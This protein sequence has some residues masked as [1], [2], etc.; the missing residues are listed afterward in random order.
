MALTPRERLARL[1]GADAPAGSFSAQTTESPAGLAPEVAGVGPVALPIRAAQAK[2]LIA[3]ARPASFGRGTKTLVDPGV[4]DTWELTPNQFTLDGRWQQ[5]LDGALD[6]LRDRLGLSPTARLWLE[7]HAM[8]VYG[9]G[10]FFL[11]H[12]DSEKHDAMVGSV[13]LWLPSV[14][15]GGEL[16]VEHAGTR[17]TYRGSRESLSFVAF[18][19]D[20][21]HEVRPVR[22]GHRVSIT[23]NLLAEEV[24]PATQPEPAA[25]VAQCLTEHFAQRA[26]SPY[27][28]RDLGLP[29]RLVFLLDHEYTE[30]G[31]AAN[32]L[33]GADTKRTALLRAAATQAGCEAVLALAEIKETWDAWPAEDNDYCHVHYDEDDEDDPGSATDE[34]YQLNDLIEAEIVLGWWIRPD[35]T[36]GEPISL[37][38]PEHEVCTATPTATLT[39]YESAFEGYMGNYGNTLD[40]WYR[41]AAVVVWPTQ[42]SFAARAEASPGWALAEVRARLDDGDVSGARAAALSME[43][44]WAPRADLLR[45]ALDVADGLDEAATATMLLEP[46]SI[47]MTTDEHATALAAVAAR[48]GV[49][50]MR[51]L[52]AGWRATD[53][54]L[55]TDLSRWTVEVLPT[56]CNGLRAA[57]AGP[58]AALFVEQAWLGL[59]S[60]LSAGVVVARA[61][62][63]A[64][65]LAALSEPLMR[66]L[67]VT[68]EHL[69]EN[70][71]QALR[72]FPETVL[73]CALP[74]LRLAR[75]RRAPGMDELAR[76]CAT[77]LTEILAR[78]ARAAHDWSIEWTGCGCDRCQR[79]GEFLRSR[80]DRSV[81]WPLITEA[82][83]HVHAQIDRAALPVRHQTRRQGRPYTLVLEKTD[84]LH[85]R[86]RATRKQ[87]ETDLAWLNGT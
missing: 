1:L 76:D 81:E 25:A 3:A 21:R 55:A 64:S 78:P 17:E 68:D 73:E 36:G 85:L 60:R 69:R 87:A 84:A 65:R 56:L 23:F 51:T 9:K 31:L 32:R 57:D 45:A 27:S 18:Y 41:R 62:D 86:D 37:Y 42:R 59:Q 70:I 35:G 20:C 79:L 6:V 80:T 7:P 24:D 50:W 15:T 66:L 19:A 4:R 46:F 61:E 58:V 38:V 30:R 47:E 75:R 22:S 14:H 43:S 26:V 39:P 8:L 48:Y 33:K 72:R 54:Y 16:V 29:N 12:Q 5:V 67:G 82:R 77:R 13:V 34:D 83:R 63:R 40:R 53:P 10:Q 28:E 44:F 49:E 74:A 52:I 11:P 71:V 2:Q